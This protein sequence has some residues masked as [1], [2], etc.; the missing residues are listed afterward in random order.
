MGDGIAV[1]SMAKETVLRHSQGLAVM[2]HNSDTS[3]FGDSDV[4]WDRC[5]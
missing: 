4:K 5:L 3:P 2:P 1:A